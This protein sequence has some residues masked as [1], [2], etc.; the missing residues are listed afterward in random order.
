LKRA[1]RAALAIFTPLVPFAA[2][3]G[4]LAM[5]AFLAVFR[6]LIKDFFWV[7]MA[8]LLFS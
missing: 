5:R 6:V 4:A 7:D 8:E 3:K 2:S 1:A